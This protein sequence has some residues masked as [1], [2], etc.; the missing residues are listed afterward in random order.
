MTAVARATSRTGGRSLTR[1]LRRQF[2]RVPLHVTVGIVMAVWLIPTLG[3]LINSFRTVQ[4]MKTSGW[5]TSLYPPANFTLDS[6]Q[7]ILEARG[8][9][10]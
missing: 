10:D 9:T 1:D 7:T 4:D 3:L 6:Y 8:F 5:W 2:R